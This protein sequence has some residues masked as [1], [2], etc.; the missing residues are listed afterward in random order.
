MKSYRVWF[1][2]KNQTEFNH[3]KYSIVVNA[4]NPEE[5]KAKAIKLNDTGD[6]VIKIER[7]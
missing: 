7:Y 2:E 1:E 4:N 3:Y 6:K 5:A